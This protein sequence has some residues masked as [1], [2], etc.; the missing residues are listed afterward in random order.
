[1]RILIIGASGFIG[2]PLVRDL[3]RREHRVAA[4]HRGKHRAPDGV[5]EIFGDRN[6]LTDAR[7]QIAKFAPEVVIDLIL[8]SGAQANNL[9]ETLRGINTRVVAASSMDVYRASS[10]FHGADNGPLQEVPLTE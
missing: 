8:S 9:V 10:V 1:M 3:L 5:I 6:R 7:D 2:P 4:L